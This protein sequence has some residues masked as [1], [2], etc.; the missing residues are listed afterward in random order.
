MTVNFSLDNV[1]FS[2]SLYLLRVLVSLLHKCFTITDCIIYCLIQE[3]REQPNILV[4][5]E[6]S[7]TPQEHEGVAMNIRHGDVNET[8]GL[9][10]VRDIPP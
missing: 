1:H 6:E 4:L 8:A 2:C 5:Q 10:E 9:K 3:H 7:S